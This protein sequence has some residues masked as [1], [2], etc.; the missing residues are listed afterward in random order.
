MNPST[1]M[2][3]AALAKG[4][5]LELFTYTE[6]ELGDHEVRVAITHC[7]LC[8]TDIQAIDDFYH[9]TKFPFVP[10]HEIVGR[11]SEV[12]KTVSE[13]KEGAG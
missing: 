8:F 1:I 9:I 4:E 7:G 2:G 5:P 3:F 11:V 12:G 6:P 13:L 10:G